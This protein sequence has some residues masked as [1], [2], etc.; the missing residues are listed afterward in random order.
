MPSSAPPSSIAPPASK[1]IGSP[2]FD[3]AAAAAERSALLMGR[4]IARR[5]RIVDLIAM[6]GVGAVYLGEHLRTREPVAIKVLHPEAEGS[7]DVVARFEREALVAATVEHPNVVSALDFGRLDDGACYLVLQHV[8]GRT[9]H[10]IIKDGPLGPARAIGIAR[11]IAAG[12]GALHDKGFVHRDVKPRNVMIADGRPEQVKLIDFGLAKVPLD[13]SS[14]M[15][16]GEVVR[17]PAALITGDG[18]LFGTFG[19]LAPEAAFGMGLV[20]E[21]SDLYALGAILYEMLAG[22]PPFEAASLASLFQKHRTAAP[23]SFAERTPGVSVPAELEAL[24]MRLLAKVPAERYPSATA[25]IAALAPVAAPLPRAPEDAASAA[26]ARPAAPD[27]GG[28]AEAPPSDAADAGAGLAAPDE[29]A[30]EDGGGADPLHAPAAPA[31]PPARSR[32]AT[33]AASTR[34]P[35]P[36]PPSPTPPR[37]AAAWP[38][39]RVLRWAGAALAA[40][41][42]VAIAMS[43]L[44]W[45]VALYSRRAEPSSRAVLAAPATAG[46]TRA[47]AE[48][49]ATSAASTT[50]ATTVA[51]AL[52]A[53]GSVG[54][55]VGLA[56]GGARDPSAAPP[57]PD[58]GAAALSEPA[59]AVA[60]A[61]PALHPEP[62][63]EI[64]GADAPTW[65][66]R[67]R[68]SLQTQS[69]ARG[70]DAILALVELDPTAFKRDDVRA[71][72]LDVSVGVATTSDEQ[73]A[74]QLFDALANALG[75]D[76]IDLLYQIVSH[77]GGSRA[78]SRAAGLLRQPAILARGTPAVRIAFEIRDASCGAKRELIAR[79]RDEG[80]ER[81][82]AVLRTLRPPE[83]S[84]GGCCL[85]WRS[86]LDEG[87]RDLATRIHVAP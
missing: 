54:G 55:P 86:G 42:A 11:Q 27:D 20:D 61:A 33:A 39:A 59:A 73:R 25:A 29:A 70:A 37:S 46:E 52:A 87:I 44:T 4:T 50:T 31:G 28:A 56:E 84:S 60:S 7:A 14:A 32:S 81:A 38:R 12:L 57:P 35:A 45:G 78:A 80:D 62:G 40:P 53:W 83:C 2:E 16:G 71:A 68:I 19:Y 65:H 66:K 72:V 6:G 48:A 69:Y 34:S 51:P 58:A 76:G 79:A 18:V 30:R 75:S 49:S 77:R 85:P 43:A 1:P 17:A 10:R 22:A 64:D 41:I 24:T 9:L 5:Y 47:P 26:E 82:L 21:R 63:R 15:L 23:P 13:R 8:A 36:T 3:A 67:L 74:Q